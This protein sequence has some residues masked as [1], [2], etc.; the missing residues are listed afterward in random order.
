MDSAFLTMCKSIDRIETEWRNQK[1]KTGSAPTASVVNL[2]REGQK[3]DSF[4]RSYRRDTKEQFDKIISRFAGSYR[5][6]QEQEYRERIAYAN[7]EVVKGYREDVARYIKN[8]TDRLDEMLVTPPSE[9]QR[10]LLESLKLRGSHLSK[11]EALRI[12]PCFYGNYVALKSFEA[13]CNDAGYKLYIPMEDAMNLYQIIDEFK[14]Y[15]ERIC[16]QIGADKQDYIAG[17]FF[18]TS[19]DPSYIE[20]AIAKF[21]EA[22]DNIPQLQNHSI[23]NLTAG[24]QARISTLFKGIEKLDPDKLSDMVKISA[25]VQKIVKDNKD[26]IQT[27]LKSPYAKYVTMAV[28]LEKAKLE[29][30][31]TDMSEKKQSDLIHE[32][33]APLRT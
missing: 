16:N 8:K 13:I 17:S 32:N 25:M 10:A 33:E 19:E 5:D 15:M 28:N 29:A 31:A 30:I 12:L 23:D 22:F 11:A 4:L 24:E 1:S 14:G 21:S 3:M 26:D 9:N 6:K 7:E 20:P 27:I 2:W 18:F